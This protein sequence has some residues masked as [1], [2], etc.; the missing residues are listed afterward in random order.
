MQNPEQI[1][2]AVGK[3]PICGAPIVIEGID[4]CELRDDG[5]WQPSEVSITCST[6]PDVDAAEWR[7]WLD[8][9]F[10]MPYVDWLP[11]TIRVLSWLQMPAQ[12]ER[13]EAIWGPLELVHDA[14]TPTL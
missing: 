6:E 1:P 12:R 9:H 5:R 7:E 4:A 3:C 14:S 8:G 13:V 11:L 10:S 2:E